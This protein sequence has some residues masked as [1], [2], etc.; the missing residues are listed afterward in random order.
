MAEF[1]A[2]LDP[3]NTECCDEP[4][5]D[6]SSGY[7][8]TCNE[9]C[10]A[11]LLLPVQAACLSSSLTRFLHHQVLLPVQESCTDFLRDNGLK[12]VLDLIND[13]ASLCPVRADKWLWL[14]S[15]A[16]C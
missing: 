5:E 16:W 7:P 1:Q 4:T 8:A 10:A 15:S 9:G 2:V 11:V 12:P 13:A 3:I 6:C 14:V